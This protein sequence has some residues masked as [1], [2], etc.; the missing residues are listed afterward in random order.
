MASVGERIKQRRKELKISQ[1][2]LA[3]RV[4]IS[5]ATLSQLESN[6]SHSTREIAR[7]AAAL[8]VTA[9]WLADGKGSEHDSHA[10]ALIQPEAPSQ[11]VLKLAQTLAL[12]PEEKLKAVSIL[13]GVKL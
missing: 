10:P 4:G 7:L 11:R 6:G 8:G 5:Q 12:L 3:R 13:L 2:D 9:L 1:A